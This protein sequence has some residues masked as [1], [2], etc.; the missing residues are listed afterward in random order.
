MKRLRASTQLRDSRRPMLCH[1]TNSDHASNWPITWR[2]SISCTA[3]DSSSL[4]NWRSVPSRSAPRSS[5]SHTIRMRTTSM[6]LLDMFKFQQ[7]TSHQAAMH[8]LLFSLSKLYTE[9]II[10]HHLRNIVCEVLETSS[11]L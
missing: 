5:V 1:S 6:S 3:W 4:K 2:Q 7:L 11:R 10:L 9:S 8:N